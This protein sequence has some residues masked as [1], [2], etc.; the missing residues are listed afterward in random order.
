MARR[1]SSK[2]FL[3]LA[4][5]AIGVASL[6]GVAF[7]WRFPFRDQNQTAGQT[8]EDTGTSVP[9]TVLPTN[10]PGVTIDPEGTAN[11]PP[12]PPAAAPSPTIAQADNPPPPPKDQESEGVT[13]DPE[14]P[15]NQNSPV[16]ALW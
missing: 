13:I 2:L 5:M 6:V 12:P 15:T 16:P 9:Q 8:E 1:S 11:N 4:L 14:G 3:A 7:A 10:S